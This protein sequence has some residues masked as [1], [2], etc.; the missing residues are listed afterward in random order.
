ASPGSSG[1]SS[2]AS[3]PAESGQVRESPERAVAA[4]IRGEEDARAVRRPDRMPDLHA[5]RLLD[6]HVQSLRL[7]ER[8]HRPDPPAAP[9]PAIRSEENARSV[10]APPRA[11]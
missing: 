10:R 4:P 2:P 11:P 7:P 5:G 6:D 8:A 9:G 3:I 1:R